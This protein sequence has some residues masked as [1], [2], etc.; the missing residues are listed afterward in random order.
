MIDRTSHVSMYAQIAAILESA[1]HSGELQ[2]NQKVPTEAELM[3]T[4]NV[5]RM[6]ARQAI[7]ILHEK[8]LV[9]RKQGKG[10]FVTGPMLR[11]ELGG[12]EAFYDSF[13]KK[14]L[15]PK[16]L[17]MK[18]TDTPDDVMEILGDHFAQTLFLKRVYYRNDEIY[19]FSLMYLPVEL[20]SS[21]TWQLAE[22]NAGYSLLTKHA[23]YS[24]KNANLTI[25]A[26]PANKEQAEI[27]NIRPKQPLLQLSR[28]SYTSEEQPIEHIK[29]HLRSDRCEFNI[30]VPG[31]YLLVDGIRN[32]T[33]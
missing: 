14:E 22:K 4:Y 29:L 26:L 11:Q 2:P 13:L 30:D 31:N 27:L 6:T 3:E 1:I 12:M 32:T 5:S 24:L 33:P 15:E 7:E 19:G 10:T 17:E 18:V 21:V 9:V 16:L 25:R 28:T 20:A 8:G 23:G